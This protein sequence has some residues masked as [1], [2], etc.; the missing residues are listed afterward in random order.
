MYIIFIY[1]CLLFVYHQPLIAQQKE[2]QAIV[3]TTNSKL[4]R[5]FT[6]PAQRKSL[7]R[8]RYLS[9]SEKN[10]KLSKKPA[11][12]LSVP[13][14]SIDGMIIRPN[15]AANIW[16]NGKKMN[17]QQLS[18]LSIDPTQLN[19]QQ[20]AIPLHTPQYS[21]HLKV[22]QTW[23]SKENTILENYQKR[24]QSIPSKNPPANTTILNIR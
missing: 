13:T 19:V 12:S 1:L 6:T 16:V 4:Q 9:T 11:I 18:R 17:T 8:K 14:V 5:L 21:I 2:Q 3:D 24:T 15:Q 22:G 10:S 7:D 23:D 20:L